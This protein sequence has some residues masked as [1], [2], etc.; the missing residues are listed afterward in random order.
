MPAPPVETANELP[1]GFWLKR[2]YIYLTVYVER[3]KFT[4]STGLSVNSQEDASKRT[5]AKLEKWK[6]ERIVE[7]KGKIKTGV[8]RKAKVQELL[9]LYVVYLRNKEEEK[10][11]YTTGERTNSDRVENNIKTNLGPFFGALEPKHVA[12]KL[13]AYKEMRREQGIKPA[14]YNGEFRILSA[15]LVRGWKSNLVAFDDLPKEYPY[16][17]VAEKQSARTGIIKPDQIEVITDA[18]APHLKPVFLACVYSGIRPKELRWLKREDVILD[19][20]RPRMIVRKHKSMYAAREPKPKVL[21]VLPELLPVLRSWAKVTEL[22]YPSC[23]WFFHY[24]GARLGS[25]NT[26]WYAALRRCGIKKGTVKF[27]DS[28]RT[29]STMLHDRG[30]LPSDVDAQMGHAPGSKVRDGYNQSWAHVDRIL[31]RVG[32]QAPLV[33]PAPDDLENELMKLKTLYEKGLLPQSIYEAKVGAL[34]GL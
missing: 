24:Q 22:E 1:N 29:T 11:E 33:E 8:L 16:N 14:T 15:A 6:A 10:G 31:D 34:M 4:F 5:R 9:D 13:V 26:A 18:L 23:E 7:A 2:D 12:A 32:E 3:Q 19:D 17:S 20:D 21:A 25:W 28:R 27:Y 30:V